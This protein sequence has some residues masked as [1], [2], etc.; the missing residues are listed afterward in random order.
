MTLMVL[1]GLTVP[2]KL[3]NRMLHIFEV[4]SFLNSR[5]IAVL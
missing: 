3:I 1:L 4:R 2:T 5:M